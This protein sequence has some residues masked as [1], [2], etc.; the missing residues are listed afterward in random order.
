M[1]LSQKGVRMT[2]FQ[3]LAVANGAFC[4]TRA[5]VAQSFVAA[6][7]SM[8]VRAGQ[9]QATRNDVVAVGRNARRGDIDSR[10]FAKGGIGT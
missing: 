5:F 8:R 1:D 2:F 6:L 4:P 9:Y 3:G 10:P 7:Y